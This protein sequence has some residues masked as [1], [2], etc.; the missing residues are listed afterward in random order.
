MLRD[1]ARDARGMIGRQH[2]LAPL[3]V[4]A[5]ALISGCSIQQLVVDRMGDA[6]ARGGGAYAADA[7]LELVGTATPFGLKLMESLIAESPRH[8]G[9]LTAAA[10]GFTQYA[11]AYVEIPADETEDRDLA[12][13][14]AARTRARKLYL[15]AR[16][17]GLRSLESFHPGFTERLGRDPE[18]ALAAARA[19]DVASLYWTAVAWGAAISLGKDDV[20]SLSGLAPMRLMARRALEL[21]DGYDHGAI[22][23]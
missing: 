17:Y 20:A 2:F 6:L 11:Y 14:Y 18:G 8:Q 12:A 23:V 19:E 1:A 7:D 4:L 5:A 15:R 3:A 13:A 9:L 22:H 21:D 10:R 16:D